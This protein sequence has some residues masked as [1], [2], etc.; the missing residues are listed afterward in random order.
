MKTTIFSYLCNS[1]EIFLE[2]FCHCTV[3]SLCVQ[4]PMKEEKELCDV[5]EDDSYALVRGKRVEVRIVKAC[6]P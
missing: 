5:A 2:E 4:Y 6:G 1:E 3:H